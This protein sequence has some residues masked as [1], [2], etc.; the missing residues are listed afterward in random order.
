MS[1]GVKPISVDLLSYA[2]LENLGVVRSKYVTST[3]GAYYDIPK[4]L[5]TFLGIQSC[6]SFAL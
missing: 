4:P 5:Y 3:I 6:H 1:A 2:L